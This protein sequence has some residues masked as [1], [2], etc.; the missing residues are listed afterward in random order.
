MDLNE[1]IKNR[2]SVRAHTDKPVSEENLKKLMETAIWAPSASNKFPWGIAIVQKKELINMIQ[3]VSPGMLG[4]PAALMVLCADREKA[5]RVGGTGNRDLF[6]IMDIVHAAQNICLKA[7]ELGIGT[8]CIMSFNPQAVA[9][10]LNLPENITAD[11][12]I[13]LGYPKGPVKA[14]KRRSIDE[15]IISWIKE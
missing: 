3:V 14:P 11:Y 4:N 1:I 13:S 2:R 9:E 10:L 15:A 6:C 12:I 5:L 7:T 8:C